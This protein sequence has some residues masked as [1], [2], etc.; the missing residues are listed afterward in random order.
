MYLDQ[1]ETKTNVQKWFKELIELYCVEEVNGKKQAIIEEFSFG[2]LQIK[3]NPKILKVKRICFQ[4][5]YYFPNKFFGKDFEDDNLKIL[6]ITPFG[7]LVY[8]L[9]NDSNFESF[10]KV[11]KLHIKLAKGIEEFYKFNKEK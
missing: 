4:F 6:V 7:S 10:K 3:S 8:T 9:Y 1:L 2:W 5:E 11:L